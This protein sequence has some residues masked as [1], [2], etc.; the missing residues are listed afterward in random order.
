LHIS[1]NGLNGDTLRH[2]LLLDIFIANAGSR[3]EHELE[4]VSGGHEQQL[5]TDGSQSA[6][7]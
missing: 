7:L 6:A 5:L 4:S 3:L 1:P 2:M